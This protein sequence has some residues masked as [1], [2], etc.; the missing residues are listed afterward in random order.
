[1]NKASKLKYLNVS[2][3]SISSVRLAA[4]AP[5]ENLILGTPKGLYLS[6]LNLLQYNNSDSDT[7]TAQDWSQL[8]ELLVNDCPNINWE[9]LFEKLKSS[10]A[11][12][13][14]L[15]ITGIDREDSI[16]WLDQFTDYYGLDEDG[17]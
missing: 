4:G 17:N 5:I 8:S 1:L 3:T 6:N 7:L 16:T 11:A 9:S 2:G 15:R 10:N 12:T 14:Y 13:K